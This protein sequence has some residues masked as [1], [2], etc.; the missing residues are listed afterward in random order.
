MRDGQST[1][2]MIQVNLGTVIGVER[3]LGR[4]K[5]RILIFQGKTILRCIK[6]ERRRW[7]IN[8]IIIII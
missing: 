2:D 4:I 1:K 8:L 3:S 6:S 5:M 7:S